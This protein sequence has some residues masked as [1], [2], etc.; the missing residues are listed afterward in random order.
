[1]VSVHFPG[2][3]IVD[4]DSP[5][6]LVYNLDSDK[7]GKL[8]PF[9]MCGPGD[10]EDFVFRKENR[11]LLE[12]TK[13]TGAN[14]IYVM[15]MRSHGGDGGWWNGPFVQGDPAKGPWGPSSHPLGVLGGS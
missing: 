2:Q 11:Y 1:V 4:P 5:G 8:D 10:P 12:K 15:A 7:N 6:W 3:I 9:F 14:C 13:G